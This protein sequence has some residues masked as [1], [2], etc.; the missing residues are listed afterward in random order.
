MTIFEEVYFNAEYRLR[1]KYTLIAFER[2]EVGEG[3]LA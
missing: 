2:D 3:E 1:W